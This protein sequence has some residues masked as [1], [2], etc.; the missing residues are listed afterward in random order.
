MCN[1]IELLRIYDTVQIHVGQFILPIDAG[2][3]T[4]DRT[5]V[6]KD[7]VDYIKEIAEL[8]KVSDKMREA[9]VEGFIKNFCIY[10]Y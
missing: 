7:A 6:R 1:N 8:P 10:R 5:G 2:C 4:K 9:I 3:L